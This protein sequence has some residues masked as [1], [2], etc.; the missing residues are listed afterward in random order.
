[1]RASACVD[2]VPGSTKTT[3]AHGI[4]MRKSVRLYRVL[5]HEAPAPHI[6]QTDSTHPP[7]HTSRQWRLNK[8]TWLKEL[9]SPVQHPVDGG[10]GC[11]DVPGSRAHTT[12]ATQ[13]VSV[14]RTWILP[15][16]VRGRTAAHTVGRGRY[17]VLGFQWRRQSR[18]MVLGTMRAHTVP[19]AG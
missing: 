17:A 3:T 14:A 1:M 2:G 9:G 6:I 10:R 19:D 12:A 15:P 8:P 18:P 7:T 11:F 5:A 16:A 4:A 13:G